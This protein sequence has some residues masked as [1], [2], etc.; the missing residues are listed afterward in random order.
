MNDTLNTVKKLPEYGVETDANSVVLTFDKEKRLVRVFYSNGTY[1]KWKDRVFRS[2]DIIGTVTEADVKKSEVK[3]RL[4]MK[5]AIG[6]FV[7]PPSVVH[8]SNP[9]ASGDRAEGKRQPANQKQV[10]KL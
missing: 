10:N 3:V 4:E 1:L 9:S 6:S 5:D 8:F 7:N 2:P